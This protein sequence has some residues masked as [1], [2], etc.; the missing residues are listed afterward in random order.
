MSSVGRSGGNAALP[1]FCGVMRASQSGQSLIHPQSWHTSAVAK[2]PIQEH[3]N[4][5]P[6]KRGVNFSS[7]ADKPPD[8]SNPLMSICSCEEEILAPRGVLCDNGNVLFRRYASFP[9]WGALPSKTGQCSSCPRLM[10]TSLAEYRNPS[11]CTKA[12]SCSSSTMMIP[13]C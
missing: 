11:C 7:S 9:G 8:K 4:L 3:Q 1:G 6:A 13:V 10:A 5:A 12:V 2:P